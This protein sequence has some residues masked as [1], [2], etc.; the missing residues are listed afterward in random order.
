M[1]CTHTHTHTHLKF[2]LGDGKQSGLDRMQ[3]L[4]HTGTK[5]VLNDVYV[6]TQCVWRKHTH[7][8]THSHT[9][10]HTYTHQ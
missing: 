7:T 8:H 3:T 5:L 6:C 1:S 9:L 4:M 2:T 10:T